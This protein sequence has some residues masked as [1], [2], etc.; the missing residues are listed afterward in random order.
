[1]LPIKLCIVTTVVSISELFLACERELYQEG[2]AT[3]CIH[4]DEEDRY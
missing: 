2:V 1:M 4:C 3:S